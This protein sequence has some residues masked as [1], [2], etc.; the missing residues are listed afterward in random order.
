VRV[1]VKVAAR[2][3]PHWDDICMTT[4]GR[5]PT[6]LKPTQVTTNSILFLTKTNL[7]LTHICLHY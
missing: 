7:L 4:W 1:S 6:A 3:Y 5:E 2:V